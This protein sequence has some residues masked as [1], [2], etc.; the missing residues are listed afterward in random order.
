MILAREWQLTIGP[1]T[2]GITGQIVLITV[3]GTVVLYICYRVITSSERT[4]H[5]TTGDEINT[6]NVKQKTERWSKEAAINPAHPPGEDPETTNR[7]QGNK[8]ST[9]PVGDS[10]QPRQGADAVDNGKTDCDLSDT[11]FNWQTETGVSFD[12]IGG[13][14]DVKNQLHAE[15]IKPIENPEKAE[16]LG[17]AAPNVIFHGPPGTGKTFTAEAL[18]TELGLPFASLSG[19]DVQSKWINE[20]STKVN[21]LFSEAKEMAVREGGA[22]VFLDELDSVL[23]NR[24]GNG[25]SHEE[26]NKVVNEFLNHLED[27]TEHGIVFVGATNR[28]DALDDAGI[29]SGRI[30]VKIKIGKPDVE[31][32]EEIL[33]AQLADR[34]HAITDTRIEDLAA[35]TDGLVAAD[36]EL[37]VNRAA[38]N[39]L[40]RG[41]DV[42]QWSDITAIPDL[43]HH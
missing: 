6:E 20:S 22:V 7:T 32:R 29:R 15:V 9:P 42:I 10:D 1:D 18:A 3:I 12:D 13:M 16:D 33:R 38:K 34:E 31:T 5:G 39:V 23:K 21:N 40:M 19:A 4:V 37:L 30:D 43:T 14:D 8:Q 41:G 35:A 11:E 2:A 24:S 27:T 28:L 26:D 17:V 36:L 25:R